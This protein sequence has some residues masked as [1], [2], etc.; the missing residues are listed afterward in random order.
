MSRV[1]PANK[2]QVT[3]ANGA[4]VSS[5]IELGK[6]GADGLAIQLPSA[7]TAADI[8]FQG[9]NDDVNDVSFVQNWYT[10]Y[11]HSGNPI[12]MTGL[13]T[14]GGG[15]F[16]APPQVAG[17]LTNKWLRLVSRNTSTFSSN[18]NQGAERILTVI[19]L[20]ETVPSATTTLSSA[21]TPS[22]TVIGSVETYVSLVDVTFTLDTSAYASGDVLADTQPITNFFRT[23]DDLM[24]LDSITLLDK[25][26][27]GVAMSIVI[28]SANVSFGTE[29]SAPSIT[30]TNAENI[31]A[32]IDVPASGWY[33]VGGAK[34]QRVNFAP[35]VVK[36]ASGTRNLYVALWN[37]TG[38]PTFTASGIIGKFGG[39]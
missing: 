38:T 12:K 30:D 5:G 8:G 22:E 21:P 27:Q 39:S 37:G 31:L 13:P 24:Y 32:I 15:V 7:W 19:T 11:D 16:I 26:D 6:L 9:S 20:D 3:F 35:V 28:L 14:T 33:D 1:D 34:V 36:P 25:D 29:N 18:V 17:I 23:A 10:L 4:N 2:P